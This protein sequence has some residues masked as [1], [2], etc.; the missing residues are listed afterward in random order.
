[1]HSHYH[2]LLANTYLREVWH[3]RFLAWS[4]TSLRPNHDQTGPLSA[5]SMFGARKKSNF[6]FDSSK[7]SHYTYQGNLLWRFSHYLLLQPRM[8]GDLWCL[9]FKHFA[10]ISSSTAGL[11]H[12]VAIKEKHN[13]YC[14]HVYNTYATAMFHAL[15][16][17]PFRDNEVACAANVHLC[18]SHQLHDPFWWR[19]FGS[20]RNK[21]K[22]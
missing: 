22:Q 14:T 20:M 1:M 3:E 16:N 17:C 21:T 6:F 8:D 10:I 12:H 11:R 18:L 19:S 15:T 7:S 9:S 13:K 5:V 4:L 2:C